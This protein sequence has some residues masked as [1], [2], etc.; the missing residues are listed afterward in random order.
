[1]GARWHS[2]SWVVPLGC[3]KPAVIVLHGVLD[4]QYPSMKIILS[5]IV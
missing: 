4:V 2:I 1:M 3:I 5:P